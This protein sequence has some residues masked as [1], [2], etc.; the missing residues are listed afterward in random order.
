M[1]QPDKVKAAAK[2]KENENFRFRS[3][4]KGH[5]DEKKLDR[6]SGAAACSVS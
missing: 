3:F 4:L 1:I 5:A 6:R 2:K